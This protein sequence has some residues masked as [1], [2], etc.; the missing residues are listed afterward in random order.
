MLK[1]KK[2]LGML[3]FIID[4]EISIVMILFLNKIKK[5]VM[6]NLISPPQTMRKRS[7][8]AVSPAGNPREGIRGGS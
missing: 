1:R 7:T 5:E 6:S 3:S 4:K 8:A 2:S